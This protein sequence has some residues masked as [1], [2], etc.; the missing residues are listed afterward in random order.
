M[1]SAQDTIRGLLVYAVVLP[2]ALVL[3]YLLATSGAGSYFDL[4]TWGPIGLVLGIICLPLL[5]K[6]HHPF[7]FLVWNMTAIVFFLP[8]NLPLWFVMAAVSLV[9]STATRALDREL[10]PIQAPS[11]VWPLLVLGA[12]VFIT[13]FFTGGFGSRAL[14]SGQYGGKQY[15]FIFVSIAAFFALIVRPIPQEKASLYVGLFFLGSLLNLMSNVIPFLPRELYWL[16]AIFPVT[17][18][19]LGSM[20]FEGRLDEGIARFHGL[21]TAASGVFFF[22][23]A[24]YGVREMLSGATW[25]RFVVLIVVFVLSMFGGFRTTLILLGSTFLFVFFTE[26]LLRTKFAGIFLGVVVLGLVA[27]VPLANK[28]PLSIQRTLTILPLNLDPVARYDAEGSSEWRLQM[29]QL[30]LPEVPKYLLTPKGLGIDGLDMELTAD[31]VRRGLARSQDAAMLVGDYHSGPLSL[32]IPFGIWGLIAWIW[33]LTSSTRAL[34]LNHRYGA[35][36]LRKVNA[37]LLAYFL[38]RT[39][40]FFFVAGGFFGDLATFVGIIALGLCLNNGICRPS[41]KPVV[42][43]LDAAPVEPAP[44]LLRPV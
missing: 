43:E 38:A 39:A 17:G 6:W 4:S 23:L 35:E 27:L 31:A 14:G 41:S 12:V 7:L 26:G 32:V 44:G 18:N 29:W 36:G 40:L 24:R 2:I 22:M 34:W 42:V 9:L 15:W 13:G 20:A 16:A 1:T 37:F 28:L 30:V 5:L 19:D 10:R 33:F 3:G 11:I 8:G 25:Q 21:T